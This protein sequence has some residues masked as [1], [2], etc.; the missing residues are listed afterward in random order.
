M[1]YYV[2]A[3]LCYLIVML[4]TFFDFSRK[5]S[6]FLP[7]SLLFNTVGTC[8]WFLLVK[9]LDEQQKIL[10]HSV[11][12]DFMILVIGYCLPLIIFK[13]N[14]NFLQIAGFILTIIG[15]VMIKV[16]QPH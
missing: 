15:M 16:S 8:L 14:F 7:V 4:L 3:S 5:S 11:Y 9:H 1:K 13:F 12:W 10:I 2:I 6:W